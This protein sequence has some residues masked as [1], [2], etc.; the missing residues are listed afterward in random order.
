M[1][2]PWYS[3][4]MKTTKAFNRNKFTSALLVLTIGLNGC[5]SFQPVTTTTTCDRGV[6]SSISCSTSTSGGGLSGIEIAVIVSAAATFLV[7]GMFVLASHNPP[8]PPQRNF[9][10]RSSQERLQEAR[11]QRRQPLSYQ[12]PTSP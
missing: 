9:P 11:A 10:L 6:S 5:A 2:S 7:A 3:V 12:L 4:C 1:S 8:S